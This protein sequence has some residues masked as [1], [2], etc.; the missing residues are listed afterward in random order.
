VLR[1]LVEIDDEGGRA[2]RRR[3]PQQPDT[4]LIAE[5]LS[6]QAP[7]MFVDVSSIRRLIFK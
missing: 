2:E 6:D 3:L 5:G 1:P 7:I 4:S